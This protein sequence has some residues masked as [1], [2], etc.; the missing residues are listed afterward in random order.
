MSL[1]ILSNVEKVQIPKLDNMLGKGLMMPFNASNSGSRKLMFG[2]QLEHR[3]ALLKPEVPYIQTGYEMGFGMNSS[4]HIAT[5]KPY[6]VIG[7]VSKF[8]GHPTH[9]Y[10]CFCV[11]DDDKSI[12]LFERK[13]YKHITEN[14]GYLFDNHRIDCFHAGDHIPEGTT[15]LKSMAFDEY[16]N[17]MDGCNLL[18]MYSA[19][20]DTM[21]DAIIISE[22]AAKKLASPLVKKV[23]V[24]INDNDIPLN[25]YGDYDTYK[26]FPDVNEE[27]KN[28]IL[29]GLRREKKEE[30]LFSQS[31]S[32]LKEL[33]ISDERYTVAGRVVD[34][35]VYCNAPEKLSEY[36][37]NAQIRNYYLE[38]MRMSEEVVNLL[39]SYIEQGY[40]PDYDCQR[41]YAKCKSVLAGKMYFSERVFSNII[42]EFTIIEEIP[43]I[44]GDK[45]SNRYGGKGITSI[46]MPDNNMPHTEKGEAID[47][48]LNM[49]GVYGRE[50][51]GQLFEISV[52]FISMKII[53]SINYAI[54]QDDESVDIA[55]IVDKYLDFL[56]IVSPSMHAYMSKYFMSIPDEIVIDFLYS[57]TMNPAIYLAI[58]PMSENMTIDKLAQLYDRFPEARFPVYMQM[59][60]ED[61]N[62]NIRYVPSRRPLVYGYQYIYR[63]KQYAEEKFSVTS[64][65]ATNIRNEN[66][67]S[68]SSNNYKALYSRTPIRFGDMESGN[69]V[70]LGAELVVQML[71]LYSTSPNARRLASSMLTGDAFDID[72]NLDM[73]STNRNVEILNVY[74]KTMGLRLK[75]E[76]VPKKVERGFTVRPILY[77]EDKD[78][79]KTERPAIIKMDKR[80]KFDLKK[81]T[82]RLLKTAQGTRAVQYYPISYY[83]RPKKKEEKEKT[84]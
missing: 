27:V 47:V 75:F 17:R 20:E 60:I 46:V 5:D 12:V 80:E 50:N 59:P 36:N 28:S 74:L 32:R 3:L 63:L 29:C 83:E 62:G 78:H 42:M 54:H 51:P 66:S 58:E 34:I 9:H 37:Y 65:S 35:D 19:C 71:M 15:I 76:K 31:Y 68:K 4:S 26:A 52:S 69:L 41:F 6:T 39:N 43:V 67:K 56:E 30:Y 82:E 64:L 8:S 49:C 25:L 13:E 61:S 1:N 18:T 79:P 10:Y 24:V 57:L 11:N 2:T 53:E 7:T 70:H 40:K 22:S 21:E 81:E 45:L 33:N 14:Y 16:D 72:I 77:F 23:T 38:N 44:S 55:D 73:E 48:I 84:E